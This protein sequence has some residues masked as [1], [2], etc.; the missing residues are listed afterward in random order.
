MKNIPIERVRAAIGSQCQCSKVI[1]VTTNKS[2]DY[3]N[4]LPLVNFL[5]SGRGKIVPIDIDG[6]RI[7]IKNYMLN[8]SKAQY[9]RT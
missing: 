6:S 5:N 2:T 7:D 1:S 4:K 9:F 8:Y 3:Q